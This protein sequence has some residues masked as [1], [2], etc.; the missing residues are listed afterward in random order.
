[1]LHAGVMH[2][3]EHGLSQHDEPSTAIVADKFPYEDSGSPAN[4]MMSVEYVALA[5]DI[6][7]ELSSNVT[8]VIPGSKPTPDIVRYEVLESNP[9]VPD[10][11]VHGTRSGGEA[12]IAN[13]SSEASALREK[14]VEEL[15][16]LAMSEEEY[17][18]VTSPLA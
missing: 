2:V 5:S 9:H 16:L 4:E 12:R 10:S 17:S 6:V 8:V 11:V 15:E 13:L 1:M 18:T 7:S 14:D 3:P